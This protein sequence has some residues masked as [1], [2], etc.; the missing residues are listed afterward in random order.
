M[1]RARS[2]Y[3]G[4]VSRQ[5]HMPPPPTSPTA[6][7][8]LNR[9]FS[10]LLHCLEAET[11]GQGCWCLAC[12]LFS[13]KAELRVCGPQAPGKIGWATICGSWSTPL[14]NPNSIPTVLER[15]LLKSVFASAP[16]G[17]LMLWAQDPLSHCLA[18]KKRWKVRSNST[19]PQSSLNSFAVSCH[20]LDSLFVWQCLE[21]L[22]C[23]ILC[24]KSRENSPGRCRHDH[25]H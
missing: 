3:W 17:L 23:T 11:E 13:A 15:V 18:L 5:A 10:S 14:G 25:F 24:T 12:T 4:G 1:V 20:K 8:V 9:R 22:F 6:W 21:A 7:S 2:G 19:Q 16:P